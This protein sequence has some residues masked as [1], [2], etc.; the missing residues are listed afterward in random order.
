[1]RCG[2]WTVMNRSTDGAV[3]R[4]AARTVRARQQPFGGTQA[5][6][7]RVWGDGWRSTQQSNPP[8][9]QRTEVHA[10]RI[11]L[12]GQA[13]YERRGEKKPDSHRELDSRLIL[14]VAESV[15]TGRRR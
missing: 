6:G 4:L 1:M 8:G 5:L 10:Q 3:D 14:P 13:V 11:A 15:Q 2:S 7:C 9:S 12:C